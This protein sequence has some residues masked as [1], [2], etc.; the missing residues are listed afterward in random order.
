MVEDEIVDT[1]GHCG[2]LVE[3][4]GGPY[5]DTDSG[6]I[7]MDYKCPECKSEGYVEWETKPKKTVITEHHWSLDFESGDRVRVIEPMDN[8]PNAKLEEGEKGTVISSYDDVGEDGIMGEIRMDRHHGGLDKWDNV[9]HVHPHHNPNE[10]LVK[11]HDAENVKK[12][13]DIKN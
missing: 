8:Y 2:N 10:S 11:I 3:Y 5:F 12:S 6:N 9:F 13:I 7:R 1:C 4:E